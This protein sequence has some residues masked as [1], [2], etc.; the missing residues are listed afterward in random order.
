MCTHW[1]N[2]LLSWPRLVGI[3]AWALSLSSQGQHWK[4]STT[5]QI[6]WHRDWSKQ[7]QHFTR[8]RMST[9]CT[10]IVD[11]SQHPS[12]PQWQGLANIATNQP[13]SKL[14]HQWLSPLTT[15]A[16]IG[17]GAYH[18]TL[19]HHFWCLHPVFLV[20]KWSI[21]LPNPIPGHWHN[22]PPHPT[23]VDSV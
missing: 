19:P 5:S 10:I 20:I 11:V 18:L 21:A 13:L 15:K 2:S 16:C 14:S 7:R 17:H 9:Q 23:V 3:L 12:L 22:L 1:C 4:W 8:W 6:V